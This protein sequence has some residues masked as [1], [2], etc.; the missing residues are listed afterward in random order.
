M[1]FSIESRVPFLDY[2]LV[3]FIYSLD[4]NQKIRHGQT[5]WVMRQALKGILPEKI[6]N[7]QDKIGF[8]TPEQIWMKENFKH[9]F[10][11]TFTSEKFLSRGYY[12]RKKVIEIF[13]D[14][15]TGKNNNYN[16]LWRAYNLE[17]W[18]KTFID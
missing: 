16:L 17:I 7:R 11:K 5:K 2:R 1:A 3:E 6:R 14:F 10:K 8:A 15:L 9:E 18:F 4:N 13:K 12:N